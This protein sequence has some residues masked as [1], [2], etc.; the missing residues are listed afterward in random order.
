[1]W[2]MRTD[3]INIGSSFKNVCKSYIKFYE[4]SI[5]DFFFSLK[6]VN[7]L[8]SYCSVIS[9]V[10]LMS[11]YDRYNKQNSAFHSHKWE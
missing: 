5:S 9:F 3:N 7:F 10:L 6:L 4:K 11:V 1:M 8:Y 2:L